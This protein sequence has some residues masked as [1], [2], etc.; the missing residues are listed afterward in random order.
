MNELSILSNQTLTLG[1]PWGMQELLKGAFIP[2]ATVASFQIGNDEFNFLQLP[3]PFP[4]KSLS[5][6]AICYLNTPYLWGGKTPFG[7]DCSGFTQTVFRFFDIPIPRDASQQVAC[8]KEIPF[9]EIEPGDL[10][11]FINQ[12]KKIIHVGIC[13]DNH[14]IIHASGKVRI[15]ILTPKGIS[16]SESGELTHTLHSIRRVARMQ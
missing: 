8:G 14:N 11:F 12:N 10:A 4:W 6:T 9:T 13:M 16:H 15:D 1:T 2:R 5:E 3:Q 7:I